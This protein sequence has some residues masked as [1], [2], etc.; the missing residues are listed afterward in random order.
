MET[1]IMS[2]GKSGKNMEHAVLRSN[3][4]LALNNDP[5]FRDYDIRKNIISTLKN[6]HKNQYYCEIELPGVKI[7][8]NAQNKNIIIEV[9]RT[10]AINAYSCLRFNMSY[11]EYSEFINDLLKYYDNRIVSPEKVFNRI[12]G[13][14]KDVLLRMTKLLENES[15]FTTIIDDY[16]SLEVRKALRPLRY[17]FTFT[18]GETMYIQ[19]RDKNAL[20]YMITKFILNDD[21]KDLLFII[22]NL[23]EED[24]KDL[25]EN[26]IYMIRDDIPTREI[27]ELSACV[28]ISGDNVQLYLPLFSSRD[29]VITKNDLFDIIDTLRG[30]IVSDE[31]FY[32]QL[33]SNIK[34][35]EYIL[36]VLNYKYRSIRIPSL[37]L[38]FIINSNEIERIIEIAKLIEL[39][40]YNNKLIVSTPKGMLTYLK[41][42]KIDYTELHSILC[43]S[44]DNNKF[45]N[46]SENFTIN[47]MVAYGAIRI[48]GT[49]DKFAKHLYKKDIIKK[50]FM[51]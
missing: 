19:G 2:I 23:S 45:N 30:K 7:I 24:S 29:I 16:T 36:S 3:I 43:N 38:Y 34:R 35:N 39:E 5:T 48:L 20:I 14:P 15:D 10:P 28:E 40:K 51:N 17:K 12:K 26:L 4:I 1:K 18:P 25:Y 6:V 9:M 33:A 49:K 42:R 44:V 21:M 32:R 46:V 37:N 8:N 41:Q 22:D 50:I 11:T 31:D 47:D 13:F 27:D